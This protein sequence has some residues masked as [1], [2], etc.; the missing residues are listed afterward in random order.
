MKLAKLAQRAVVAIGLIALVVFILFP[1]V[2]ILGAS[3]STAIY[4]QFPPQ[5]LTLRWYH[6]FVSTRELT[7]ST[8]V[9]LQAG[10]GVA[11]A[12][13]LV[14]FLLALAIGRSRIAP[15]TRAALNLAIL[16]PLLIPAIGLG[17]GI[18]Y[19]YIVLTLPINLFTLILA[20][21]I[22]VLPLIT[23]LLLV[24]LRGIR[25]NVERAALNLGAGPLHV[26]WRV[27]LPLMRPTLITAAILGFV[28][29]FDD[30]A[31]AL[32]INSPS[33]T[34]LPVRLLTQLDTVDGPLIAA[35]GSV[36]LIIAIGVA[37]VLDRSIGLSKAF[38]LRELE[39]RRPAR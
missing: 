32:F 22:L 5:A 20:Q 23:G 28:R 30:S 4:W 13:T 12:G 21:T 10:I 31:V 38:G 3:L 37:I 26:L 25:P 36:L 24:G 15:R 19:L 11:I 27:I 35:G 39:A 29:S 6:E 34:T 2:G 17:V 33:A 8:T 9:S 7:Q 1:L 18:Y 16:I 14:S